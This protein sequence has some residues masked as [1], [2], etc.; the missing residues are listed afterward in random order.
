MIDGFGDGC[1]G[2]LCAWC[3]EFYF[4]EDEN[5]ELYYDP[6]QHRFTAWWMYPREFATAAKA[7][8]FNNMLSPAVQV[9]AICEMIALH[10]VGEWKLD[11]RDGIANDDAERR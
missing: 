3:F 10:V 11:L 4:S 1:C 5:L 8:H 9:D 6:E 2:A 7:L